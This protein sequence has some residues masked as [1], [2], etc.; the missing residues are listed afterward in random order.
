MLLIV[1]ILFA[2]SKD[3]VDSS[4]KIRRLL[5]FAYCVKN[6]MW[7]IVVTLFSSWWRHNFKIQDTLLQAYGNI[8]EFFCPVFA[9]QH[10]FCRVLHYGLKNWRKEIGF[11]AG[12][13]VFLFTTASKLTEAPPSSC[14]VSTRGSYLGV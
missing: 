7:F 2:H 8:S 6:V 11:L 5:K 1:K 9:C 12:A 14:L 4:F 10:F 3:T 13:E